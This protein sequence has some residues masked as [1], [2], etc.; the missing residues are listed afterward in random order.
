MKFFCDGANELCTYFPVGYMPEL[1]YE[2]YDVA[3]QVKPSAQLQ[4]LENTSV[5][6]HVAY[7]N[8][9]FTSYQLAFRG[10]FTGISL[11]VLCS[12]CTKIMCRIPQKL[13]R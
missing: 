2:M 4:A 7:V 12:Y 3:I 5:N 8:A 10:V 9:A 1:D 11:L 6:F 13:E